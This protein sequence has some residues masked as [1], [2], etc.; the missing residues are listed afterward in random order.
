MGGL[1]RLEEL[2]L[3]GNRLT[4]PIPPEIGG[5]RSL[6]R[7]GM[8]QNELTGGLPPEL[9]LLTN[10]TA[11]WLYNNR[12]TGPIPPE[13]L[14]LPKLRSLGLSG[15]DLTL[16]AQSGLGAP[17]GSDLDELGLPDCPEPPDTGTGLAPAPPGALPV[18]V[19]VFAVV[20]TVVALLGIAAG[21]RPR[22]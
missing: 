11:L 4:G 7:L 6:K 20:A 13:I 22:S 14:A 9:G 19:N 16:C 8:A 21:L 5:L 1:E 18:A 2:N 15:N 3:G 12:L 17:E 10:L